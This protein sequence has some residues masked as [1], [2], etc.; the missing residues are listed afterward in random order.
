MAEYIAKGDNHFNCLSEGNPDNQSLY[1]APAG[2][3]NNTA[4]SIDRVPNIA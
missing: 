3:L 1:Y 2:N 4:P